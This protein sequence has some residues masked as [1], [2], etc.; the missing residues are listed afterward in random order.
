MTDKF[1]MGQGLG[2]HLEVAFNRN[3]WTK[4]DVNKLG[5][6]D[7]L[8]EILK[9]VRNLATVQSIKHLV[10]LAG[11]PMP[12]VLKDAGWKVKKH[13]GIGTLELDPSMLKIH[14]S[15]SQRLWM[16][17]KGDELQK[18]IEEDG[19]TVLN[20]NILRYLLAHPELIPE[21]W[22]KGNGSGGPRYIYF[23]GT[24]FCDPHGNQVVRG[25]YWS[26]TGAWSTNNEYLCKVF[27]QHPAAILVSLPDK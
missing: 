1:E 24:I 18:E 21:D 3:G 10:D 14:S 17:I 7:L 26:G 11:D 19:V 20:G 16:R 4:A 5:Q 23:W 8:A 12:S 22:K 13:T 27:F 15:T 25:L 6:G 2:H 9:V